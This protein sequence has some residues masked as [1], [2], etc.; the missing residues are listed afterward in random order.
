MFWVISLASEFYMLTFRNTASSIF[1]GGVSCLI[2]YEDGIDRVYR[3]VGIQN[4]DAGES[5]KRKNTTFGT[6]RKFEIKN[7]ILVIWKRIFETTQPK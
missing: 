6:W 3:N 7:L 5:T 4:S 2:A 1:L